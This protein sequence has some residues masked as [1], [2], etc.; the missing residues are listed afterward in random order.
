MPTTI[1]FQETQRLFGP[2]YQPHYKANVRHRA[3]LRKALELHSAERL[4]EIF[5]HPTRLTV[6]MGSGCT[7]SEIGKIKTNFVRNEH[8]VSRETAPPDLEAQDALRAYRDAYDTYF[9]KQGNNYAIR[10]PH[11]KAHLQAA[12]QTW[13]DWIVPYLAARGILGRPA[14]ALQPL[15]G[16]QR[17][18]VVPEP[19]P[20]PRATPLALQTPP[21]RRHAQMALPTPPPSSPPVRAQAATPYSSPAARARAGSRLRPIE[22]PDDDSEEVARLPKK[23]KHLGV[24]EISDSEEEALRPRK[25]KK[26]LGV[27]DLTI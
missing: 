21:R 27:V 5:V 2:V 4:R 16:L 20:T 9:M 26:F 23:R 11:A 10:N 25:K 3:I 22:F 1:T 13:G 7:F 6:V 15:P 19:A 24:I 12:E 18:R 8:L 17:V 14:W